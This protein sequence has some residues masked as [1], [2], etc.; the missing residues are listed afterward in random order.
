MKLYIP[1][2]TIKS[3]LVKTMPFWAAYTLY[4]LMSFKVMHM[5]PHLP[6]FPPLG[7]HY[8]CYDFKLFG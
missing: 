3:L 2:L 8:V 4:Q 5:P 1:R 6:L 7:F